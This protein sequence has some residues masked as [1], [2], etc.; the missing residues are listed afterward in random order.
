MTKTLVVTDSASDISQGTAGVMVVPLEVTFG[1]ESFLD[2]VDLSHRQFYERLIESDQ[3]PK[4]SMVTPARFVAA[5]QEGLAQADQLLVVTLS[6]RLSGTHDSALAAAEQFPGRV[7]VVDSLN[8]SIGEAIVVQRGL[9]LLGQGL[10]AEKV[11]RQLEEERHQVRLVA[12]LGT[13]EY[14]RKGGRLNAAAAVMG[15]MLA[16]KPVIAIDEGEV[17]VLG[18][19]RGS[20]N[21]ANL[22][23]R[24][25]QNAGGVDFSR[26]Y[27]VGY[28]GLSDDLLRKYVG[29]SADLWQESG[30][31]LPQSCVGAAIGTHAGP[32]A[33]AVA[34]FAKE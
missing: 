20:K 10:S 14:L 28:T 11:A 15:E 30:A 3:L 19:A 22:L 32:D 13:L 18:K 33:I 2:G 34:F 7:F 12:L 6:G 4:T 9:Q 27:L 5:F 25:I 21:G 23:K 1:D 16:I 17:A 8:A 26:P 29:D 31:L 24:Q